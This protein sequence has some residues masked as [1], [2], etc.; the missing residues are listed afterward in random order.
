MKIYSNEVRKR[1][2]S[3]G[4]SV[5]GFAKRINI[6]Q[7]A[8]SGWLRGERNPK[9]N[10]VLMIASALGCKPEDISIYKTDIA[11]KPAVHPKC[12]NASRLKLIDAVMDSPNFTDVT[13][14]NIIKLIKENL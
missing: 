8:L 12:D 7:T 1:I 14:F 4:Y 5:S 13:K 6:S 2:A 11:A 10:S 9:F 3:I